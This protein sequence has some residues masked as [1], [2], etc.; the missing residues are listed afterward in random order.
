MS[1]KQVSK[2]L[3]SS[4]SGEK[5]LTPENVPVAGKQIALL[6]SVATTTRPSAAVARPLPSSAAVLRLPEE[7]SYDD[8][9]SG[10]IQ[11]APPATSIIVI[12]KTI[13]IILFDK[14]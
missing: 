3:L 12:P 2:Y 5:K 4:P 6:A 7:W 9:P 10:R 8:P 14:R 13:A 11:T 1:W